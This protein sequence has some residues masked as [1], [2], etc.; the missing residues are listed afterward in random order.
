MKK[1]FKF[2]LLPALVLP[3]LFTSCDE[4]RDSNPSLDLSH[5][6]EGFV[7]N[8]PALAENNTYDLN[9]AKN[10]VLTCSQPNYG[11]VP[12][13]VK[14]YAQVSIDPAFVSDPT[15]THKE[16]ATYAENP[17]SLDFNAYEANKAV[18]SLFRAA[19]PEANIPEKMSVYIRLRAVIGGTLNQTLGETYSNVITLPS[20]K[21][22][23]EAPDAKF[24]DNLYLIGSSIQ[25]PWK[26]WK[27]IPKVF[28]LEGN[29]YGIIYLPAGGEFKWGTENNDYRGINRL[30]E[31]NDVAGAGISAGEEQNIK[32]ANAGWYTLLF[33]G[34]ITED[35]KNID[36]T[37]SVYPTQV[38]ILGGS[39]EMSGTWAF[40]DA[41]ALTAPADKNGKWVSPA[42][43]ASAELRAA[44]KV[45]DLDWYRTEFT[46]YKGN[47]FWRRY[48]I[49]NNWAETE[50]ADYSVTTQVGQKLYI[51]FDNYTA[52]V[53]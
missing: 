29:Y 46:V 19:N 13:P 12:Y 1:I 26:S 53:K 38:Y 3:L 25:D 24:T 22:T 5:L 48:D 40:D 44:V 20:V 14:Y 51:D 11:G 52:E 28:G 47:L 17:S 27:P 16:L 2:M 37:L 49:V 7:L 42:F 43:T 31:I 36:W 6:A 39:V 32:V 34:K 50:G 15:V 35:K 18:V 9:S 23:Y 33:K 45:G 8:I 41:Y 21:A 4:D 30:K 10:L